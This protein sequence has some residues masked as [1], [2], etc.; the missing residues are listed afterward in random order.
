MATKVV[1]YSGTPAS[2]TSLDSVSIEDGW[3]PSTVNEAVQALMSHLK[4]ITD[5]TAAATDTTDSITAGTT[6]TQAG[7]T[8]APSP[9]NRITVCANTNDGVKLPSAIANLVVTIKNEGANAAKVWPN[10]SD[11]VDGGSVDAADTNTLAATTGVRTYLAVDATDWI[12][13]SDSA[14]GIGLGTGDSPQFTG[15]EL[16]HASDTTIARASAGE[17][18]VEGTQLAKLDGNLQDLDTLGAASSDGEIAVATGAGA[19]AWESGATLRTSVGVGTGDSP[20]FTALTLGSGSLIVASGQGVDFSATGNS[21]A[22]LT[23]ELF[24]DYEEGLYNPTLACSTSGSYTLDSTRDTLAYTI[25]GRV[26]HVQGRIDITGES[27]PNG[28]LQLSLPTT[29]A[30]LSEFADLHLFP[31]TLV[32]HGDAGIESPVLSV[33]GGATEAQFNNVTDAGAEEAIDE[34]R[35]DTAFV[36]YVNF[37]YIT[38]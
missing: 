4:E 22:G 24:D 29:T 27:S 20:E 32:G 37:T 16:G 5:G 10:T 8:A 36:V 2:N 3:L 31:F 33:A 14:A 17:I 9:Y 7:A 35:V 13:I 18:S 12:T 38:A 11:T 1:D 19:L 34:S 15:I 30:S 23:S 26:C 21:N 6:Q 28:A 25:I